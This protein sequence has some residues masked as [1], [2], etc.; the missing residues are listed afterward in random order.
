MGERVLFLNLSG[1]SETFSGCPV[2][3]KSPGWGPRGVGCADPPL[4]PRPTQLNKA[5][6][7]RR[8]PSVIYCISMQWFQRVGGLCQGQGQR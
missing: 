4:R 5:F 3:P 1:S 6:R 7:P 8:P 2:F